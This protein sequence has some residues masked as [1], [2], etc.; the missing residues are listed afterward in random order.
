VTAMGQWHTAVCVALIVG[1]RI[2]EPTL[3]YP[4]GLAAAN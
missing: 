4:M 2:V 1:S 3:A